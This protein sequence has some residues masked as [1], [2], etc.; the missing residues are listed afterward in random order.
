[1]AYKVLYE[2]FRVR[3]VETFTDVD[4]DFC[5]YDPYDKEREYIQMY[6]TRE[7]AI[8]AAEAVFNAA[9]LRPQGITSFYVCVNK[10]SVTNEGEKVG[11]KVWQKYKNLKGG[12]NQ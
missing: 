4:E 11:A 3:A 5:P 9:K 12:E 2:V 7:A 1:M 6:A 10:I 8:K